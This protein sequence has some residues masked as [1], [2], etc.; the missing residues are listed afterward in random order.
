MKSR[1]V[2]C[3]L[4]LALILLFTAQM[5]IASDKDKFTKVPET[6]SGVN[7]NRTPIDVIA[8]PKNG[9]PLIWVGHIEDAK[10]CQRDK[11]V[12]IEWLCK[13][14]KFA[15]PGEEAIVT[16][17]MSVLND[18]GGYFVVS[19]VSEMPIERAMKFAR[20]HKE[21]S[22]YLL[23][24]GTMDSIV[25]RNGKK[26]VFVYT[27]RMDVGASLVTFID[28][29]SVMR[30]SNFNS[31]IIYGKDHSFMLTAPKGWVI[32]NK[33]GVPNN[34]HAVFYPVGSS[35]AKATSIMYANTASKGVAGNETIQKVIDY[36]LS[37]FRKKSPNVIVTDAEPLP[38][39]KGKKA[40]AK[41]LSGDTFGNH[42]AIAYIDENKVVVFIVLSSRSQE[43]FVKS[44][45]AFKELVASYELWTEDVTIKKQE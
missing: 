18:S 16:R 2:S 20:N 14:Y 41:Y 29:H 8:S 34:L 12:E 22:H 15:N 1:M 9:E 33:S 38:T 45:P 23:V 36:D 19:L 32:D 27:H 7:W 11:K 21:N 10:V 5:T 26:A 40:I 30:E 25:D 44:L 28:S 17:P 3:A 37:Q 43:D 24:A 4:V 13:H 35:W 39:S 31:G 42:E 6:L